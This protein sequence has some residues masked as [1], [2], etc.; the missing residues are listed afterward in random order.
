[1]VKKTA[2]IKEQLSRFN[3][4]KTK[5]D[6]QIDQQSVNDQ[7]EWDLGCDRNDP[8]LFANQLV[9]DLKLAPEFK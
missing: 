9:Y 3:F 1:M 8:E 5:L 4:I 7:F 2:L 6:I